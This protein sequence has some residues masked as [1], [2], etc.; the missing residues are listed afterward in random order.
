[1]DNPDRTLQFMQSSLE[2]NQI[3]L[4]LDPANEYYQSEL[5]Q[6][7]ANLADAQLNVCDLEGALRSRQEQLALDSALLGAEPEN[8]QRMQRMAFAL[9]GFAYVKNFHGDIDEAMDSLKK[10]LELFEKIMLQNIDSRDTTVD[11]LSRQQSL[12]HLMALNGEIDEAWEILNEISDKWLQLKGISEEDMRTSL[13]YVE[14]L[15]DQAR[16]ANSRGDTQLANQLLNDI[17]LHLV[18][19]QSNM[20]FRRRAGSMLVE[21]VFLQWEMNG[22]L[23]SANILSHLPEY[24]PGSGRTRGCDDAS[25]AVIKAL[26]LGQ[27]VQARKFTDYLLEKGYREVG[28]MRVCKQY[29]LCSGQ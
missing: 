8:I 9:T 27:L 14:F 28:F 12:V 15:I 16:L 19:S 29:S 18:A 22:E 10:A 6:S 26:M 5:G 21:V 1:V 3:A 7:H 4:V 23:P 25:K 24:V 2:Y 11:I 17:Q 20:S 13:L